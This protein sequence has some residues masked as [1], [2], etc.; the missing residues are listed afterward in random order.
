MLVVDH[1]A[2]FATHTTLATF[3]AQTQL[4]IFGMAN[5]KVLVRVTAPGTDEFRLYSLD[6]SFETVFNQSTSAIYANF[7]SDG[8]AVGIMDANV[9][10]PYCWVNGTLHE[11][12]APTQLGMSFPNQVMVANDCSWFV[13]GWETKRVKDRTRGWEGIQ[14]IRIR[15]DGTV[16]RL[17]SSPDTSI[18]WI[19]N[20]SATKFFRVTDKAL[21][22]GDL[23][24]DI[25]IYRGL[26]Q[27]S[28][29]P[30]K[31]KLAPTL[32]WDVPQQSMAFGES[33]NLVASSSSSEP[34][35]YMVDYGLCRLEGTK[36]IAEAGAGTCSVTAYVEENA[37]YLAKRGTLYFGLLKALRP[38][39]WMTIQVPG[40]VAL[41][42]IT[43]FTVTTKSPGDFTLS[44]EGPCSLINFQLVANGTGD[45]KL[46]SY[47]D[48]TENYRGYLT[49]QW[50]HIGKSIWPE[51]NFKLV[52]V[53]SAVVNATIDLQLTNT[54]GQ[55]ASLWVEGGCR[56]SGLRVQLDDSGSDCLVRFSIAETDTHQ[57][58]FLTR[59]IKSVP[60]TMIT[61]RMLTS[62]WL[63]SSKLPQGQYLD[64]N[65]TA[66][67]TSG[68]CSAAGTRV[69]AN[70]S[71]GNCVVEV[72]GYQ[73]GSER[74]TKEIFTIKLGASSQSWIKS[75]PSFSTKKLSSSKYTFITSGQ[76][77]T[78]YGKIGT[79]KVSTGCKIL[80]SGTKVTIDMGKA[81]KCIA[82]I[83][84]PG[85]FKTSALSK[86]WT[87]T[88]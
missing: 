3:S 15:L 86:T 31:L 21:E 8:N 39:S 29:V 46:I 32:L 55:N 33:I 40:Q 38:D 7:S 37:D 73:A 77:V 24:S 35:K 70:G 11:F 50:I 9:D 62:G 54:T 17:D 16:T 5:R 82:T 76:P 59:T 69:T 12:P 52:A 87:F 61:S 36:V 23:N 27:T 57:G 20:R 79:W 56:L 71:S 10:R 44:V 80:K 49:Y 68:S 74:Y 28:E 47:S 25:D 60:P 41:G 26:G 19:S 13:T 14:L 58:V 65:S 84:A 6:G 42:S 63:S 45:C 48:E 78:N 53:E 43:N 30:V 2:E 64:F 1:G 83:S 51:D 66:V 34:I 22:P 81:K 4:R 67:I 18:G 88:R 85:G 75:L 72:G